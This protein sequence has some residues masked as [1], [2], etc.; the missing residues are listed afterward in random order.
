MKSF[1]DRQKGF[2]A[3]FRRKEE[4]SFRITARR[5]KLLGL[6]A[7]Q[8]LG[9]P[10]GEAA[11]TYAMSVVAADFQA[12]GDDDVVAKVQGDL[13]EKGITVTEAEVRAELTRAAAEARKQLTEQ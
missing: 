11:N 3:E 5:N 2:E 13:A 8:R 6:W 1:E 9:I 10:D 7:A 4:L 12:P